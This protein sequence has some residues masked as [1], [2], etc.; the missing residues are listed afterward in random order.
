[1]KR[2]LL[3]AT[4]LAG[5][6]AA[7]P[8]QEATTSEAV[9]NVREIAEALTW[10]AGQTAYIIE[11]ETFTSNGVTLVADEAEGAELFGSNRPNIY[12]FSTGYRVRLYPQTNLAITV[13][14]GSKIESVG[15]YSDQSLSGSGY[16]QRATV[17]GYEGAAA[18]E[19]PDGLSFSS[20]YVW[21]PSQDT[22]VF[23]LENNYESGPVL[24][25]YAKVVFSNT[26]TG[27][28]GIS[29]DVDAP[30]EYYNLNG[31]RVYEPADGIFIRRQG[32]KVSKVVLK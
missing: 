20:G 1:M 24:F 17:E 11:G 10:E 25:T 22:N 3:I 26:P 18:T 8:A 2:S 4:L 7:A 21:T 29:S 30:V 13:P 16:T 28:A 27:I 12:K 31:M 14:E 19:W 15:L 6:A 32:F 9:F 23:F 5:A